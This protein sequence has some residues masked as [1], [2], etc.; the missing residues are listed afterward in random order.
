MVRWLQGELARLLREED[1]AARRLTLPTGAAATGEEGRTFPFP[2][3]FWFP[4]YRMSSGGHGGIV[5]ASERPIADGAAVLAE[6]VS[7]TAA[8]AATI[9]AKR[10]PRRVLRVGG[11][12]LLALGVSAAAILLAWPVPMTALAPMEVAPRDAF[13]VAAPIDGVIEDILVTPNQSVAEGE[14][15]VRYVDTATRNQ[16]EI[17][18]RDLAVAEAKLRQAMQMAFADERAKRDLAQA[19]SEIALKRA[20]REFAREIAGKSVIVAPRA[21]VVIYADRKDWIGK[22]V[23]TGQKILDLADVGQV[24]LRAHLPVAD[25]LD[26]QPGARVRAFLDGDPLRPVEARLD[27]VSYQA[28]PI[29]G[30]G[31]G[32]RVQAQFAP[33]QA[34]PRAGARGTAQLFAGQAPLALHLFRRPLVW[35]R[36][37]L[38][39]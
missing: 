19:R 3:L 38:G 11:R 12:I 18:E 31:L 14:P 10:A 36:Q 9:L 35:A 39:V 6:R 33:G 25:I 13:V 30:L 32:Y 27:F 4:V 29:E 2:H 7:G 1:G 23:S 8:H 5:L 34:L 15:L 17:A 20:E 24:E 16:L 21:G 22:P 37:K 28:R 26:L